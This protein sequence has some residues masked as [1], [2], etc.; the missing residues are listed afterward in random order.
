MNLN[1]Q[2]A[3]ENKRH[4]HGQLAMHQDSANSHTYEV[5]PF[6]F[7]SFDNNKTKKGRTVNSPIPEMNQSLERLVEESYNLDKIKH[8]DDKVPTL[9]NK[10]GLELAVEKKLKSYKGS[11]VIIYFD[12]DHFKSINDTYNHST[13]DEAIVAMGKA[14]ENASR[15][16][17]PL[18]DA[19]P[20]TKSEYD[21]D[22]L[23]RQSGDE[24][25]VLLLP[26]GNGSWNAEEAA[27]AAVV[28]QTRIAAILDRGIPVI[29]DGKPDILKLSMTGGEYIG[30]TDKPLAFKE[31][32][33]IADTN[34][35]E[36]KEQRGTGR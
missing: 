18:K 27:R 16:G 34:M 5:N 32:K 20:D 22:L 29:K 11:F 14:I 23:S 12:G 30:D 33:D 2:Q 31:M 25:C 4:M 8:W 13:G 17:H 6:S 19:M 3:T 35:H 24:F 28:Y 10:L 21:N 15:L 36:R 26:R 9:L 1:I 7:V